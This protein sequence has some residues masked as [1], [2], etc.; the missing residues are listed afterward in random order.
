MNRLKPLYRG[1]P[2][3]ILTMLAGYLIAKKYLTYV[4]PM[5][6]STSK[7]KLADIH[8]GV[9]NSNLYKD[10][11]V[12]VTSNKISAEVELLKSKVLIRKMLKVVDFNV[13]IFRIGKLRKMELYDQSPFLVKYLFTE[14]NSYDSTFQ[15]TISQD[16]I[17]SLKTPSG[18]TFVSRFNQAI[19]LPGGELT[20]IRND[21]LVARKSGLNINDRYEFIIRSSTKLENSILSGLDVMAVDKDVPV[22]RIS[23]K[24]PVAQ[25]SADVVNALSAAYIDDYIEEKFKSADTTE[26]FL[27]KQLDTFSN[28]LSSSETDIKDYRNQHNIINIRQE[29]ETDLRKIADLKKQ[30]ASLKMNLNAI[31]TLDQYMKQGQD[32]FFE[33]APNF[34]AFT[35][36]LSTELVKKIKELQREKKDLLIKYTPENEKVLVVDEKLADI[37]KYLEESIHNTQR[38]LRIQYNDLQHSIDESE[39]VFIGLPEKEKRM[40]ILERNFSMNEEIYRFLHGKKTDAE[41]AKAATISFHRIISNG[42]VPEKPVSPN[43]TI[44][45]ILAAILGMMAGIVFIYFIHSVKAKVNDEENINRLSD[46]PVLGSIPYLKKPSEQEKHFR[47][48]VIEMDLKH[49]LPKGTVICISSFNNSEGKNFIST[50]LV[51]GMETMNRQVALISAQSLPDSDQL[52]IQAWKKKLQELSEENDLIIILT[53]PLSQE[54]SGLIP[55]SLASINMFILDSRKTPKHVIAEAEKLKREFAFPNFVFVLN[56]AGYTPSLYSQAKNI[57]SNIVSKKG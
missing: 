25:K 31:D 41:I 9:S 19:H 13:D 49:L 47:K 33:L 20:L 51:N 28:K 48:W 35:D 2:I 43:Y 5:Y 38:S 50:G 3:V 24:C 29:T 54:E 18:H 57:L 16:S 34:E 40:T 37:S 44:I 23:Y 14:G 1:I 55:M 17:I 52:S 45:K 12:F 39:K 42:E 22:I 32:R 53:P 7:I 30:L 56:R 26:R 8:E 27:N 6:E 15:L 11:D 36:L 21:D 4:T 46:I 10:F